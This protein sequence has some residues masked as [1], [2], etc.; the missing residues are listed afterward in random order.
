MPIARDG[1]PYMALLVAAA[2]VS[3]FVSSWL[4]AGFLVLL[5]FVAF[6]F[7]DPERRYTGPEDV[8]LAPADGRV[9]RVR[10]EGNLRALSI[11]LSIF[12]VHVNRAPVGGTVESVAYSRGGFRAA[13]HHDAS[14]ENERN[15]VT[16]ES[17]LGRVTAVQIAGL[18]ARRI[19]C[20]LHAGDRVRA[21]QRMGMIKF[22]SRMD[23]IVPVDIDWT[24]A[25][26]S[27][28][29]AGVTVIG[30]ARA[31]EPG[32]AGEAAGSRRMPAVGRTGTAAAGAA[33]SGGAS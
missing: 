30:Q 15:A 11:F 33:A 19:V 22:G 28:V 20:S 12:D 23:V 31:R 32:S 18:L 24:V 3:L 29:R 7:R 17:L 1:L 10:E 8:V 2:L 21:G 9:V 4:A 16:I 26:G 27:R 13:F 5:L 25:V 14:V 6:F